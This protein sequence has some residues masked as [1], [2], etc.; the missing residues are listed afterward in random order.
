MAPP[1]QLLHKILVETHIAQFSGVFFIKVAD[2]AMRIDNCTVCAINS[3]RA[4]KGGQ[5]TLFE[6]IVS[7]ANFA[8]CLHEKFSPS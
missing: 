3:Q 4:V 6:A 8:I 5:H 7:Q 1:A 2:S